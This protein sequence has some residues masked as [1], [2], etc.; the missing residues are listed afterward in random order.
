M[1]NVN[2]KDDTRYND[3]IHYGF[4]KQTTIMTRGNKILRI[5]L[6]YN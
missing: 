3:T 4:I 6:N 2:W 5:G 1:K